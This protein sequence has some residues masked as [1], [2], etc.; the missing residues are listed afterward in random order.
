MIDT[1]LMIVF[2]KNNVIETITI[3][4]NAQL[5]SLFKILRITD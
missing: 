1:V 4:F 3:I 2:V 5:K